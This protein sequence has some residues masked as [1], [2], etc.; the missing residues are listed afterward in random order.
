M[1]FSVNLPWS[2]HSA[3]TRS[4]KH[5]KLSITIKCKGKAIPLQALI[6]PKGSRRLRLPYFK[7]IVTGR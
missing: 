2:N 7:I 6:S 3:Q 4:K 1:W 5:I